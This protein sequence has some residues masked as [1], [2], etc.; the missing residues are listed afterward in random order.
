MSLTR[1]T[2]I[3]L[4]ALPPPDV[5]EALDY[6][7]IL[8]AQ[9][10]DLVERFPAVSGVIDLESEPLRKLLEV[11]AYRE[12]RLRARVNDGARAVM[13]AFA[14]G[15]DLDQIGARYAV[16]RMEGEDDTRFRARIALAPE[17]LTVAGSEGAYQFH[18]M[19]ADANIHDASVISDRPGRVI[20]TVMMKGPDPTPSADVLTKVREKVNAKAV[21]PLTDEVIVGPPTLKSTNVTVRLTLYPGPDGSM[22]ATRARAAILSL[23]QRTHLLGYDLKRSAIFSAAHQEGVQAAEIIE[24]VIDLNTTAREV[25]VV[26]F[27]NITIAGRDT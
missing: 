5:V 23:I 24:P 6:E 16:G 26:P 19:S 20:V 13:L 22:V 21:R 9:R 11:F 18:A 27:V 7:A 2:T 15:T 4:S 1:F 10:D 25:V 17:A 3:D 12:L 8:K 14:R